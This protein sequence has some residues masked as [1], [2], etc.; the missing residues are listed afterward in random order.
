M[1]KKTIIMSLVG[2]VVIVAVLFCYFRIKEERERAEVQEIMDELLPAYYETEPLMMGDG[3]ELEYGFVEI[4]GHF[5]QKVIDTK[6]KCKEDILNRLREVY[7][8]EYIDNYCI[9]E[10]EG[11]WYTDYEN[12]LYR[13]VAD[14]MVRWLEGIQ[15]VVKKTDDEIVIVMRDKNSD[16]VLNDTVTVCLKKQTE[17][18]RIDRFIY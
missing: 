16:D 17:G 3:L 14:G 13:L 10:G 5:Y 6:Y 1:N 8:E 12:E 18:W 11:A 2:I 4:D 15:K 9:F 7:T